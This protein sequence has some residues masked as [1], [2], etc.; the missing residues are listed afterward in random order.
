MHLNL[1]RVFVLAVAALLVL[2]GRLSA[3]QLIITT[4]SSIPANDRVMRVNV[5]DINGG[6]NIFSGA[7]AFSNPNGVA[8]DMGVGKFFVADGAGMNCIRAGNLN[9][10]GLVTNLLNV[11]INIS[12]L[13]L[14]TANQK[15]YFT[16]SSSLGVNDQVMRVNYNGSG[17]VTI[18]YGGAISNANGIAIDV[19]AGKLF[20]AD[21]TGVLAGNLN[22]TGALTNLYSAGFNVTAVAADTVN[23]KIYFT[24][25][26]PFST[27]RVLRVNYNGSGALTL[28]A[29][30]ATMSNPNGLA[31]DVSNG[32]MYIADGNGGNCVRVANLD[33]TGTPATLYAAGINVSGVTP[34]QNLL[35]ITGT[36]TNQATL[37][38]ASLN[39]FSGVAIGDYSPGVTISVTVQL[40]NPGKGTFTSQGGFINFGGGFYTYT[41]SASSCTVA[42]RAMVYKPT[43]DRVPR[44]FS[45]TS[46]FTITA[47][48]GS[49]PITDKTTTVVS[50][51]ANHPPVA[52]ANRFD[53]PAG[54]PVTIP[55]STLL[56]NDTDQDSDALT[57]QSV[58]ATSALGVAVSLSGTN[59]LYGATANLAT[60]TFHYVV[61]DAHGGTATGLVTMTVSSASITLAG[62]NKVLKFTRSPSLTYRVQYSTNLATTNWTTLASV[63]SDALGQLSYTNGGPADPYRF[64]RA[65]TP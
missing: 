34:V 29:S 1:N 55:V 37:D 43:R 27:A 30:S 35:Y 4:S 41:G 59:V 39:P 11:G 65:I 15:I 19:S 50:T 26:S 12:A 22:G 8:V 53:H 54:Q 40:D 38:T 3:Q 31:L 61:N 52:N 32:K 48:D 9:G 28:F 33:G 44:G 14:D 58:D 23:Q 36:V 17:L 20:V 49:L 21:A 5:N 57:M 42:L 18:F 46:F 64:Y 47:N 6:S 16:T 25:A 63:V 62:A 60:D 56:A 2:T 45:E 7:L 51:A 13:A 24:Y 10:T